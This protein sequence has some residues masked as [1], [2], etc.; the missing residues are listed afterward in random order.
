MKVIIVLGSWSSGTTAVTG[1]IQ[2]LGAYSCP[3]HIQ[4]VDERTPDSFESIAFRNALASCINELTFER[5]QPLEQFQAFFGP[6]L[7]ARTA[8]AEAAGKSAIVL[9]HPLSAFAIPQIIAACDA[10]FLVVTRR[11]E[12]IE[13]TRARRNWRLSYGSQ[14]ANR[15]YSALYSGL[16]EAKQSFLSIAYEEFLASEPKRKLLRDYLAISSEDTAI[17]AAEDWVRR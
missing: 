16:M 14:G 17:S 3:P 7:E 8:E 11:F 12:S 15:V 9:K 5:L 2:K 4:T 10:Q 1:Y 13:A 6:W